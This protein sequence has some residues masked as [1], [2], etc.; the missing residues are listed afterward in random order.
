M[1]KEILKKY[2]YTF[3]E[4]DLEDIKERSIDMTFL[5][6]DL[7]ND[8]IGIRRCG[9]TSL[10]YWIAKTK[11]NKNRKNIIYLNCEDR[12]VYPLKLDD[13]N[14]LIEFIYEQDLLKDKVILMLDEIQAVTGWEVF[15]KSIY[16]EFKGRIKLIV[17][18]SVKS[19]ISEDYGKLISG[20]HKTIEIYPLNFPEYLNFVD[21]T[22]FKNLTEK[23]EAQIKR[24]CKEYVSHSA[25]PKYVLTKDYSYVELVFSDI[26][27]RDIKSRTNIRKKEIVDETIN[28]LTERVASLISYTKIKNMLKNKGY[29]A[30]TDIVIRYSEIF[31]NV[32]LFFFLPIYSS[33][34]S[35]VLKNPRKVYIADNGFFNLFYL[36]FTESKGNLMENTVA[37]ELLKRGFTPGK[38]LFYYSKDDF[39][40][41]FIL[42]QGLRIKQLIQVCYSLEDEKTRNRE[43]KA[44]LK[45]SDELKC[46][47]LLILTWDEEEEQTINNKKIIFMPLWKWLIQTPMRISNKPR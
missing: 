32:F 8:I 29:T 20:R 45:A 47:D 36:R 30:S 46:N 19:L 17:S 35:E 39:E 40:V 26:I 3:W 14:Y 11:G 12:R 1:K 37:L 33:K 38:N 23:K 44:L 7:I 41:D 2:I 34:Y 27:E 22:H 42:K 25:L 4:T 18:G 21:Y 16:D 43:T 15:A 10:M 5:E 6:N 28:L 13:L 9:K 24:L 31:E